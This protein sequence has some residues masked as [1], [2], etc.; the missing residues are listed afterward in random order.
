MRREAI[1]IANENMGVVIGDAQQYIW[2][3]ARKANQRNM[4]VS[5]GE[6]DMAGS[7]VARCISAMLGYEEI[8]VGVQGLLDSGSTPKEIL[9]ETMQGCRVLD[10]SGCEMDAVLY[11]VNRGTPVFAMTGASDAVLI[12]GYDAGTVTIYDAALGTARR[13]ETEKAAEKFAQAGNV[14]LAYLKD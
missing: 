10:L 1:R 14:F 11:Y 9:S 5:V 6:G 4:E 2:K 12:T 8:N 13:E 3:R 7:S